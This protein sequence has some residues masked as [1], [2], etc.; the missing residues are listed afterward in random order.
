MSPIHGNFAMLG[1]PGH[2]DFAVRQFDRA[3]FICDNSAPWS[4]MPRV[5]SPMRVARAHLKIS[6]PE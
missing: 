1:K 6:R 4:E 2:N 3:R 5:G